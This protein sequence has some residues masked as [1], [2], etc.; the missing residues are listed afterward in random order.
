MKSM[1]KLAF[2][3]LLGVILFG[4]FFGGNDRSKAVASGPYQTASHDARSQLPTEFYR[5][6]ET[7][8][9]GNKKRS[10][11]V[12]LTGA[13]SEPELTKI[14]RHIRSQAPS[15]QRTYIEYLLPGMQYEAGAW[16]TSHF[17]P[18]LTVK[19][20][21]L[22][23]EQLAVEM[24]DLALGLIGKWQGPMAQYVVSLNRDGDRVLMTRTYAS[25]DESPLELKEIS[26][27][28]VTR[29]HHI[30]EG[31]GNGDFYVLRPDGTLEFRDSAGLVHM[32]KPI[33]GTFKHDE[34]AERS[35]YAQR[36]AARYEG[37]V[38]ETLDE[39][40]SYSASEFTGSQIQLGLS[41]AMFSDWARLYERGSKLDLNDAQKATREQLRTRLVAVQGMAFPVLRDAYGPIMRNDLREF[42]ASARTIGSGFTIAEFTSEF[43]ID[44][45]S[46]VQLHSRALSTLKQMR[47]KQARYKWH[48]STDRYRY[49]DVSSWSDQELVVWSDGKGYV[50][51]R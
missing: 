12:W 4:V 13:V 38:V 5:A 50:V 36:E 23:K 42:G 1:I 47:F 46:I 51:Q 6:V 32:A 34:T 31:Y 7:D 3:L 33:A 30:E 29:F 28:G 25:G 49:F 21:G 15:V 35:T 14:A 11:T 16:A 27:A 22:P 17:D 39:L 37:E 43:F 45:T 18:G 40:D 44:R 10:V 41:L 2:T 20:L 48:D 9:I 19:I 8:R 24:E 26:S